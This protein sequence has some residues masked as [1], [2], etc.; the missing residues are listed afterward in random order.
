MQEDLS[1]ADSKGE[2]VVADRN[3]SGGDPLHCLFSRSGFLERLSDMA[4]KP[5]PRQLHLISL[6][7]LYEA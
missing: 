5:Q 6:E 3:G 4:L 1:L 7:N 2:T